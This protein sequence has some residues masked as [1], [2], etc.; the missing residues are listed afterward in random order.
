MN[1]I[2]SCCYWLNRTPLSTFSMPTRAITPLSR[3]WAC[4]R[5]TEKTISFGRKIAR[6]LSASI[7]D[8]RP[9]H[10][11]KGWTH[12][13]IDK[14]SELKN[15]LASRHENKVR[16]SKLPCGTVTNQVIRTFPLSARKLLSLDDGLIGSKPLVR[17]TS[18]RPSWRRAY[19]G[20]PVFSRH[21]LSVSWVLR[22]SL[23][24]L[25]PIRH[26]YKRK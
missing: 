1:A 16:R 13:W 20:L 25:A 12:T 3:R 6:L 18:T 14:S 22:K 5:C 4:H 17:K 9:K 21:A 2:H 10:S 26:P 7:V 15:F 23:P 19:F 8:F 24:L 11:P